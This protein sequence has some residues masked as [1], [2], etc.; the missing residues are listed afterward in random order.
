MRGIDGDKWAVK[1]SKQGLFIPTGLDDS[2]ALFICE[3]PTDTAAM[4]DMGFNAIGRPS[5]LGG[6]DLIIELLSSRA[7]KDVVI[8]S[9]QD[10]AGEDGARRLAQSLHK[11][12]TKLVICPPPPGYKDV[13]AWYRGGELRRDEVIAHVKDAAC[14]HGSASSPTTT[15]SVQTGC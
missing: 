13:R 4:L 5:C 10:D 3:G 12:T 8:M 9:D 15:L 2:K 1:G 7:N 6:R 14:R 11:L